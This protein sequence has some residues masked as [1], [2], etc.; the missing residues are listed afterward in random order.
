VLS[1]EAGEQLRA[2]VEARTG[3]VTNWVDQ[4]QAYRPDDYIELAMGA[5]ERLGQDGLRYEFDAARPDG[6]QMVPTV[7]GQ[8]EFVLRA[9]AYAWSQELAQTA[10]NP[11]IMLELALQLPS[12]RQ[13][14][15]DLNLGLVSTGPLTQSDQLVDDRVQSR[16]SL[17]I[18]FATSI[19]LTDADEGQGYISTADVR[20]TLQGGVGGDHVTN[21]QV[22]DVA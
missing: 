3:L 15:L 18:R 16:A 7:V 5:M 2:W 22:G 21:D 20:T 17:D 12:F 14:M 6:Q 8:R 4:P 19:H 9:E 11:L 13:L 1:N 10:E